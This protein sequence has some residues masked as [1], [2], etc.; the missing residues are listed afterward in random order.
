M[1]ARREALVVGI[2]VYDY[3]PL[4]NRKTPADEDATAIAQCLRK[5][6]EFHVTQL[7]EGNGV[8]DSKDLEDAIANLFC[9]Q[10][11]HKPH[12]ALLFFAG[13]GLRKIRGAKTD[14]YLATTDTKED[15][16]I[17]GVS[18]AWLRDTLEESE[19]PQQIVWL[20]CC[21]S[22]EILNFDE[23]KLVKLK[24][25]DKERSRF[26][27]AASREFE[28]AY[29]IK[30]Q[31][32]LLTAALLKG[33][34]PKQQEESVTNNTLIEVVQR[35]FKQE[36][37]QPLFLNS[38][39]EIL[40]THKHSELLSTIPEA[41]SPYK[42]LFSF[43]VEDAP[44]FYGRKRLTGELLDK[45]KIS[46]QNF[47]AVLGASG[48]GK[49]S[50][51]QAG[52]MYELQEGKRLS[53]SEK[54]K[55]LRLTPGE[56]PLENLATAFLD[57]QADD[58][59]RFEQLGSA[60]KAIAEGAKGF[61]RLIKASKSPRT[62]LI[63]D[64][65]EEVF[66]VCKSEID[67]KQFITCL[68]GALA[69]TEN[70]LCIV[71]A[72]RDDFLGK[73]A[74]Y[75]ELVDKIQTN[76]VLVTLMSA[77]QLEQ[78]IRQPAQQLN[79]K[80]EDNLV[81]AILKDLGVD[82]ESKSSAENRN[83]SEPGVL[84]LLEYTLDQLWQRQRYNTLK[85]ETYNQLGRVQKTLEKLAEEAYKQLSPEEKKVA[86]YILIKLTQPGEGTPNTRKQV[87][88]Q[89]LVTTKYPEALVSGV[90]QKLADA[91]LIVTSQ[92]R[93]GKDEVAVPVVD[94]AHEALI[95]YWQ[96]L[97]KLVDKNREAIRNERKIQEAAEEW[98]DQQ[99]SSDY[100][101]AGLRLEAAEKFLQEEAEIVPPSNLA[102]EFIEESQKKRDR[103]RQ[104]EEER[105]QREQKQVISDLS[106][107][108]GSYLFFNK[109]IEALV[110][111][112]QAGK[113]LKD[114]HLESDTVLLQTVSLV[115]QQAV[116]GV[117]ERNR[118]IG[119]TDYINVVSFSP[120]GQMI[121]SGS[122]NAIKLWRWEGKL[123]QTLPKDACSISFSRDSKT[124]VSGNYR[125]T[126]QIWNQEG[127]L[128][129]EFPKELGDY[130]KTYSISLSP[131]GKMIASGDCETI[132]L[133]SL[134]G[135]LLNTLTGHDKFVKNVTFSP[136]GKMIAS[137]S[138]D[139]TIKLWSREGKLLQTLSGHNSTVSSISFS[140]DG[141]MIAS[142]SWDL[143]IKLWNRKG[144][145]LQTLL[146]HENVVYSVNFSPDGKMIASGSND[147][148]IK[149][150][151]R[152]GKLLQTLLGHESVVS[153]VGFS[154]DSKT[155]ASASWDLTIKLWKL[156]GQPLQTLLGH[157][158]AVS[159]V[160]FSPDGQVIASGSKDKTIKL[161]SREGKLLQTLFGHSDAVSSVN[162]S[163]DGQVIASGSK[164]K[165]IKLWSREGKL[166]QTLFEHSDAVSSVNFSPD[167][168]VIASSSFDGTI[169]LWSWEGKLLQILSGH[170][171]AVSSVS[172]SPDGKM[173]ASG[174]FGGIIKLWSRNG[175]Q[176]KP[177]TG[178]SNSVY[179][180]SFSPDG[181]TLASSSQTG[182][183]KLWSLNSQEFTEKN[184]TGHGTVV[185]SV[186]FSPDGKKILASG[187]LGGAIKL[188][189][190]NGQQLKT[191]TGHS[192]SVNSVNFSPDGKTLAS[193]SE[194]NTV[195]LWNLDLDDLLVKGCNWLHDYLKNESANLSEG[196]RD[197][198]DGINSVA[199]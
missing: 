37:Q 5:S 80:V 23:T 53:G 111:A 188:W 55:I 71:M 182:I 153:S 52:L 77:T 198:C 67:R 34:D 27:I 114:A 125:G 185:N 107:T 95:R 154:P 83:T 17:W 87:R 98:R 127:H 86:D 18:L 73:C 119:H 96:R 183:V 81:R 109:Q 82:E 105:R 1:E 4:I 64:Q 11:K 163:P 60:E 70:K 116:Y 113:N 181:K 16:N 48:S 149:L 143:T 174:D 31:N 25:E 59:K 197:L 22:G 150:W 97:R 28:S 148:T 178:H 7:P 10:G 135:H 193:A 42:G 152:E 91:K 44:F 165:T 103:L 115:L 49:T 192:G 43:Q 72:M 139:K 155:L 39:R 61:A 36:K 161:W 162:F 51:L 132:K 3:E 140:P 65:F 131:D 170:S 177:L 167:G 6:G 122:N 118:L 8:L 62:V 160:N 33:L 130:D 147:K 168:Q 164:D 129:K 93:Q 158:D 136:D 21:Y 142:G 32:G 175:Q 134:D 85:L 159:S 157:S 40:L 74:A 180:V 189:S 15:K 120:D 26:I 108:S 126:I 141:E 199:G 9:P 195:I 156:N 76:L 30:G 79:R 54:W 172:F 110:A 194:D 196:D 144:K 176:L 138:D 41:G 99:K 104:E 94:V 47:L 38:P 19:V 179:S 102:V 63:V 2:S 92:R 117:K 12:I 69:H 57:E 90:I 100:L 187:D 101:F 191:L 106:Q 24:M 145:L 78:A 121:A 46:E 137:G 35:E 146:G 184:L 166:L 75:K 112:M 151:N 66:T 171:D 68:L 29:A 14:G 190:R 45:V 84:P 133:W 56:K 169:K 123:L 13:H 89:D 173:I 20:D 50:L 88:Q 128:I 186:S 58:F 124:I